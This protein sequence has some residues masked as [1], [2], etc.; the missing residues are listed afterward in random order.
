MNPHINP[1]IVDLRAHENNGVPAAVSNARH[2]QKLKNITRTPLKSVRFFVNGKWHTFENKCHYAYSRIKGVGRD[3]YTGNITRILRMDLE[4]ENGHVSTHVVL[5]IRGDENDDV[6]DVVKHLQFLDL[7]YKFITHQ[8]DTSSCIGPQKLSESG[9][10]HLG[11]N[12]DFD[13]LSVFVQTLQHDNGY[14]YFLFGATINKPSRY[15]HNHS[16]PMNAAT[17]MINLV[18]MEEWDYCDSEREINDSLLDDDYLG[19]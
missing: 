16:W 8:V 13:I 15:V 18:R 17:T 4:D 10:F 3:K 11:R 6:G 1:H 14:K 2:F 9:V 7:D 12:E 19:E 5:R